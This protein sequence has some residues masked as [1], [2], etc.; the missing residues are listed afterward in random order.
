MTIA[1]YLYYKISLVQNSA[2]AILQPSTM[3]S[4]SSGELFELFYRNAIAKADVR[5]IHL[6][7]GLILIL[8]LLHAVNDLCERL[9][10]EFVKFHRHLLSARCWPRIVNAEHHPPSSLR[11]T[12]VP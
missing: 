9:R 11:K 4:N 3:G 6:G 5:R 10:D 8:G 7:I 2:L 12:P 1:I